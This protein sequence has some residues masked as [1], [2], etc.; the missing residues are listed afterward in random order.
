MLVDAIAAMCPPG[1][2]LGYKEEPFVGILRLSAAGKLV[3]AKDATTVVVPDLPR[4]ATIRPRFGADSFCYTFGLP[5]DA[6]PDPDSG[7]GVDDLFAL[8]KPRLRQAAYRAELAA[9]KAAG[10]SLGCVAAAIEAFLDDPARPLVV[11]YVGTKPDNVEAVRALAAKGHPDPTQD[12]EIHILA[13][14][15]N[16]GKRK[17]G[18]IGGRILFEVEGHEQWWLDPILRAEGAAGDPNDPVQ[19]CQC[20]LQEAPIAR[21]VKGSRLGPGGVLQL[22]SFNDPATTSYGRKQAHNASICGP[23]AH[24]FTQGLERL[25]SNDV[26]CLAVA[27]STLW[28]RYLGWRTG[29]WKGAEEPLQG[30]TL[31]RMLTA[32]TAMSPFEVEQVKQHL[33][34]DPRPMHYLHLAKIG[35]CRLSPRATGVIEGHHLARNVAAWLDGPGKHTTSLWHVA[36]SLLEPEEVYARLSDGRLARFHGLLEDAYLR[37]ITGA[38][39]APALLRAALHRLGFPGSPHRGA[40]AVLAWA[41]QYQGEETMNPIAQAA[42]DWGYYFDRLCWMTNARLKRNTDLRQHQWRNAM[43]SPLRTFTAMSRLYGGHVEYGSAG[44]AQARLTESIGGLSGM[45][46]PTSFSTQE[47]AAF[48]QGATQSR[49]DRFAAAE[50]KATAAGEEFDATTAAAAPAAS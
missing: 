1:S 27:R 37:L 3:E 32:S 9:R 34:K 10:G 48:A 22:I 44:E 49:M 4:R 2:L 39:P 25:G 43:C 41:A 26:T 7:L 29:E 50:A 28:R 21:L 36:C 33:V 40:L 31:M 42:Y 14:L 24:R 11:P 12:H 23:C 15:N 30:G 17:K 47:Q 20:C 35:V 18:T 6:A 46:L 13:A 16:K 38:P 8:P 5:A 45:H 19:Q